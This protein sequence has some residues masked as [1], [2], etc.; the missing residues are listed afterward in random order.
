M[1][2]ILKKEII[3]RKEN[4]DV[5]SFIEKFPH[6]IQRMIEKIR[7][8]ILCSAPGI[9][10]SLK[11]KIPFYTHKGLLCYINPTNERVIIGFSKGAE[12][13]NEDNFLVGSG[14]TV[15][16]VVYRNLK[17]IKTEKLQHLIYEALIINEIH[18]YQPRKKRK[19][20]TYL[21]H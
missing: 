14:K 12:F 5:K 17:D 20:L 21:K 13:A 18:S 3:R 7:V 4:P 9:Q 6:N 10:E 1:H 15:R 2:F 11:Y 19:I 16:H 8:I